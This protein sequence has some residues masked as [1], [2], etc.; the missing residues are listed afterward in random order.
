MNSFVA[1]DPQSHKGQTNTWLTPPYLLEALGPFD[2]DP[3]GFPGHHTA[4]RVIC[5]PEDG[6]S[7]EWNGR[8]WLNPPYGKGVL[9]WLEKLKRHGDGIALVFAR[10]DAA[11]FQAIA[12]DADAICFIRARVKFLN[13]QFERK[14][15]PSA[16]SILIAFGKGNADSL[17]KVQGV[18]LKRFQFSPG[19]Q[20]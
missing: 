3:C 12:P 6:L 19:G 20:G 2:L 17:R 7:A 16:P 14:Y 8:V 18:I 4:N 15:Q 1:V 10:T 11:W 13:D 9:P 5:L